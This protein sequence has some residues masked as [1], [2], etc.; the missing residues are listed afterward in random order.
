MKSNFSF[1][2]LR[3]PVFEFLWTYLAHSV[4]DQAYVYCVGSVINALM[5]MSSLKLQNVTSVEMIERKSNGGF[6]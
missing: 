5:Q 1:K 2:N 3:C 6:A 4:H